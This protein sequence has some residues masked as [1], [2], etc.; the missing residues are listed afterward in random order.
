MRRVRGRDYR[1]VIVDTATNKLTVR[2]ARRAVI[3]AIEN[4]AKATSRETHAC[5]N[6]IAAMAIST[7]I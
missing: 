3:D 7:N 2:V 5:D 4:K 6:L 1:P